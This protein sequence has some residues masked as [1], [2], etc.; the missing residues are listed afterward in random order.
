MRSIDFKASLG[1]VLWTV[2]GLLLWAMQ[3]GCSVDTASLR[4]P[5]GAPQRGP[6]VSLDAGALDAGKDLGRSADLGV[7]VDLGVPD[8]TPPADLGVPDALPSAAD[9]VPDAVPVDVL[10]PTDTG[11]ASDLRPVGDV[12][13]APDLAPECPY[14]AW[15]TKPQ[16]TEQSWSFKVDI[17]E[18]ATCFTLCGKQL[19]FLMLTPLP[20]RSIKI[21]GVAT[22]PTVNERT[23]YLPAV[24]PID[25]L[26][27]FRVAAGD[28]VTISVAG[29]PNNTTGA[30]L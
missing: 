13:P 10:P 6:G 23:G 25:S 30:C 17:S 3:V 18:G 26:Y 5:A 29:W 12:L 16:T 21:N 19:N 15:S 8:I 22:V 7:S 27:V 11:T 28:P 1:V 20:G 2:L 14:V 9:V 24:Q 4:A